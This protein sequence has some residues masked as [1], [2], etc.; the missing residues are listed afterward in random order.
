MAAPPARRVRGP[1]SLASERPILAPAAHCLD[2]SDAR[3]PRTVSLAVPPARRVRGP[4]CLASE[5]PILAPAA[6]CLDHSDARRPRTGSLPRLLRCPRYEGIASFLRLGIS[7]QLR[8]P[9][10]GQLTHPGITGE[11]CRTRAHADYRMFSSLTAGGALNW[12]GGSG[13]T[14]A[15]SAGCRNYA[16]RLRSNPCFICKVVA[17]LRD[18]GW[19]E[20]IAETA[21]NM[22]FLGT[23]ETVLTRRE[24]AR[25]ISCG[26]DQLD[27]GFPKR[28]AYASSI[29]HGSASPI[30]DP[31]LMCSSSGHLC[32]ITRSSRLYARSSFHGAGLRSTHAAVSGT[33]PL[34][35]S[36]KPS[37]ASN[38]AHEVFRAPST[39]VVRYIPS[40]VVP[41]CSRV[42]RIRFYLFCP[43]CRRRLWL[44]RTRPVDS[45]Y[46]VPAPPTT[47]ASMG[48]D[49]PIANGIHCQAIKA[50]TSRV[51]T[52]NQ[53][54]HPRNGTLRNTSKIRL[55]TSPAS[56]NSRSSAAMPPTIAARIQARSVTPRILTG[57][58][59]LRQRFLV[60][61]KYSID[62]PVKSTSL[63]AAQMVCWR[64]C[65]WS[66]VGSFRLAADSRGSAADRLC[67]RVVGGLIDGNARRCVEQS[68][69]G[70]RR[71]GYLEMGE[72]DHRDND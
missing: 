18:D 34:S 41:Q 1:S 49:K 7:G 30:E 55:D 5:R 69:L 14:E 39:L 19:H 9:A 48:I 52:A 38:F 47:I 53:Y 50:T 4:F 63:V 22:A 28:G 13:C 24:A 23:D 70:R 15:E 54:N 31:S 61:R 71:R 17:G 8:V 2:R 45:S 29:R 64:S 59:L 32:G 72:E 58:S 51:G 44:P 10:G 16:R 3:R 68:D 12:R 65:G 26:S 62:R 57:E 27:D 42:R 20:V 36:V 66:S 25:T 21:D 56:H 60:E 37:G 35:E 6:H 43:Q 40:R 46:D 11:L 67:R 33:R